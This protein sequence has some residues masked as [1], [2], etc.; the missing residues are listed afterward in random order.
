MGTHQYTPIHIGTHGF[1]ELIDSMGGDLAVVNDARVS[2]AAESEAFSDSDAKLLRYL[3]KHKHMSPFR[4]TQLKFRVKAPEFVA[5]QFYKHLTGCQYAYKDLPW[6]EVSQRY[7]EVPD[8]Y[9]VFPNWRSQHATS[10][11]C[12]GGLLDETTQRCAHWAYDATMRQ[13]Y[14]TYN[15]LL[16][17]GVAREQARAVLPLACYTEWVWT[18]SLE[19][20]SNFIRL[21]DHD[22]AQPEIREYAVAMTELARLVAPVAVDALTVKK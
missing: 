17:I 22:H 15:Y 18:A 5:R 9:I 8:E 3:A 12:S 10:K 13:I 20:V 2:F 4:H 14:E 11:Q 6:N 16:R 1:I 19:A 7:V 21:R